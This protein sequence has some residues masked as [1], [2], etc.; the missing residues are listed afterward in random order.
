MKE[1]DHVLNPFVRLFVISLTYRCISLLQGSRAVQ[2]EVGCLLPLP[3]SLFFAC[4]ARCIK[5]TH[6]VGT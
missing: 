5:Q 3:P 1:A 6:L 2:G 4:V